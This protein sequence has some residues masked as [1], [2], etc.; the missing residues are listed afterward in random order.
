MKLHPLAVPWILLLGACSRSSET[1]GPTSEAAHPRAA[2]AAGSAA[3]ILERDSPAAN[4]SAPAGDEDRDPVDVA[5]SD[6]V[7]GAILADSSLAPDSG[8]MTVDTQAGIVTLRGF[9]ATQP[10]KQ[11]AVTVVKAVGGVV[12][13][14]DQLGVDPEA[15]KNAGPM[16]SGIDRA[17]S[18]RVRNA[19]LD[20]RTL[21]SVAPTLRITT[22][23]GV[24]RVEGNVSSA[25]IQQ[26]IRIVAGAVGSVTDVDDRTQI[27]G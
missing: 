19:F 24:V 23:N 15:V 4:A 18:F 6:H 17:I 21:S 2:L 3:R 10:L 20:D 22:R 12:R 27:S 1:A 25:A 7:R 14:D 13:V 9:V 26:R 16:E 5:I 8:A 11:R